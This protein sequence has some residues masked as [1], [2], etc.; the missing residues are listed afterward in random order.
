MSNGTR[1]SHY[2]A[3]L[4]LLSHIYLAGRESRRR[5][6]LVGHLYRQNVERRAILLS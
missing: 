1:G 5:F 2:W 4:R 3:R 6:T